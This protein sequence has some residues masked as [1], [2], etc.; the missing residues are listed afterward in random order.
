MPGQLVICKSLGVTVWLLELRFLSNGL[1]SVLSPSQHEHS[2]DTGTRLWYSSIPTLIDSGY[3]HRLVEWHDHNCRIVVWLWK[4][5]H[6]CFVCFRRQWDIRTSLIDAFVSFLQLSYV[7]FL[8]VSFYFLTPVHLYTVSGQPV[9]ESYL[10]FDATIEYFGQHHLP[11]AILAIVV[12]SVFNIFSMLLMCFYPCSWFQKF[13]NYSYQALHTFMEAFQGCYKNG[14]DATRDYRW[15][16]GVYFM[17]R[18]SVFFIAVIVPTIELFVLFTGIILIAVV[19]PYKLP[20]YN[21]VDV[22][23]IVIFSLFCFSAV[24]SLRIHEGT[25]FVRTAS[26]LI[27][28]M[29]FIS[30]ITPLVYISMVVPYYLFLRQQLSQH[31]FSKIW[32]RSLLQ[33][34]KLRITQR[35][36]CQSDCQIPRN[37][38]HCFKSPLIMAKILME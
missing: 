33:C 8:I 9:K 16:S 1:S 3:I 14:T 12:L 25:R 26:K 36:P 28:P 30:T 5:F 7:K 20:F 34:L 18:I 17:I 31:W 11:Y 15:F 19:R 29:L 10:L 23:L 21:S 35:N 38:Q 37:V 2:S 13:L 27:H 22:V 32:S 24:G 4:P 6:R